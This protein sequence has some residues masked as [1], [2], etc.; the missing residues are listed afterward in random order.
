MKTKASEILKKVNE[1]SKAK[2]GDY[3]CG[4]TPELFFKSKLTDYEF[5]A[6]LTTNLNLEFKLFKHKKSGVWIAG[7]DKEIPRPT[8]KPGYEQ[9]VV[10]QQIF[11][12]NLLNVEKIANKINKLVPRHVDPKRLYNVNGV[13]SYNINDNEYTKKGIAFTVYKYLVSIGYNLLGNKEQYFG[14]RKLW[15]RLSKETDVKVDIVNIESGEIIHNNI[16]LHHGTDDWD[17]D[18][19]LWSRNDDKN[20]IRP[21]LLKILD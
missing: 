12:I 19:R 18:T 5:K 6:T 13:K 21:I 11:W 20:H 16:D 7:F 8:G 17:F 2:E 3:D 10:F 15:S 1:M 4:T 9:E 14:A